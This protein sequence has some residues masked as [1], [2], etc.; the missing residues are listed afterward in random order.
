LTTGCAPAEAAARA[1]AAQTAHLPINSCMEGLR[2]LRRVAASRR[3]RP[4]K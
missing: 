1:R 4:A 2:S 3:A